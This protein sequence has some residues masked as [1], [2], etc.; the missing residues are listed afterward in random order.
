MLCR[1]SGPP[2]E[3]QKR[4]IVQSND[5]CQVRRVRLAG[6]AGAGHAP[7]NCPWC[8][9]ALVKYCFKQ[10]PKHGWCQHVERGKIKSVLHEHYLEAEECLRIL[11]LHLA[12]AVA[13]LPGLQ[14]VKLLYE[15]DVGIA[16]VLLSRAPGLQANLVKAAAAVYLQARVLFEQA[17]ESPGQGP[18]AMEA[19]K[20]MWPKLPS[21]FPANAMEE[22]R[23]EAAG[24]NKLLPKLI[25][26]DLDHK[27]LEEQETREISN[28]KK[29]FSLLGLI[30]KKL[31][32]S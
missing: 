3:I 27:P 28:E 8:K 24:K 15:L 5:A 2:I 10:E 16:A 11:H 18:S 4:L 32:V 13:A 29:T 22:A 23:V 1:D 12:P 26:F 31:S 30:G 7:S 9:I 14:G 6:F 25:A 21:W 17:S 19:L 20:A